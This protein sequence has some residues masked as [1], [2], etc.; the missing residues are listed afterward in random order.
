M[1]E[2]TPGCF[3]I[4]VAPVCE[5]LNLSDLFQLVLFAHRYMKIVK[6]TSADINSWLASSSQLAELRVS[7]KHRGWR[8]SGREKMPTLHEPHENEDELNGTSKD[9]DH[10]M[11]DLPEQAGMSFLCCLR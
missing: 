10:S 7:E 11:E 9:E 5:E 8:M 1:I 6:R 2:R 4:I 3:Q